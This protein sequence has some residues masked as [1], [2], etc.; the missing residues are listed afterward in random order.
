MQNVLFFFPHGGSHAI[1]SG[2]IVAPVSLQGE[3]NDSSWS[4]LA[5][6][7]LSL[8]GEESVRNDVIFTRV[9]L[10]LWRLSLYFDEGDSE[11]LCSGLLLPQVAFIIMTQWL[12]HFQKWI[13]EQKELEGIVP[14]IWSSTPCSKWRWCPWCWTR[15]WAEHSANNWYT[16][17]SWTSATFGG[18]VVFRR[19]SRRLVESF[20]LSSLAP[21][22]SIPAVGLPRRCPYHCKLPDVES[23]CAG[24]AQVLPPLA[25]PNRKAKCS[26][27]NRSIKTFLN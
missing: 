6:F 9:G 16:S 17:R 18:V 19:L 8:S 1:T 24:R 3:Q 21:G 4:Y 2:C 5:I 22:R 10:F 25:S 23:L 26:F 20:P 12:S 11:S 15:S 27:C 13:L 14:G 7:Y